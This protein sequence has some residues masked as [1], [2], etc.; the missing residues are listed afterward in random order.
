L[1][2][3]ARTPAGV[4]ATPIARPARRNTAGDS[5]PN[6]LG[7]ARR[8]PRGIR[9]RGVSAASRSSSSTGSKRSCV[10]PSAHRCRRSRTTCPSAVR[11]SR[12]AAMGG[13]SPGPPAR[14]SQRAGV[15]ARSGTA[16][17]AAPDP[18][19]ARR[20]GVEIEAVAA[21]VTGSAPRR[22]Q[23]EQF[24][25]RAT[26]AHCR[27]GPLAERSPSLHRGGGNAGQHGRLVPP[28]IGGAHLLETVQ[29]ATPG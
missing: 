11:C 16:V 9:G 7:N 2:F 13:R 8:G 10:V 23:R 29:R 21:R 3:R 20:G 25:R 19:A 14:V 6:A 28:R 17:R 4:T 26:P 24:R 27:T 1:A 18:A 22:R 15:G 12:S 5:H